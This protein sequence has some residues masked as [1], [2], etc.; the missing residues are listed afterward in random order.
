LQKEVSTQLN[1]NINLSVFH[2]N[3]QLGTSEPV[4]DYYNKHF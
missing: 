3:K 2:F 4:K 1:F